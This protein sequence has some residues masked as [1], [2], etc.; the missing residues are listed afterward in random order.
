MSS[1]Q[2]NRPNTVVITREESIR[3]DRLVQR[4]GKRRAWILL[5][6]SDALL[7][8]ACDQGRMMKKTR[9]RLVAALETIEAMT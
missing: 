3:F 5:G 9:D 1:P 2:T 4:V 7:D 6:T 8:A